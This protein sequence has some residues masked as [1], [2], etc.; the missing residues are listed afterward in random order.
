MLLEICADPAAERDLQNDHAHADHVAGGHLVHGRSGGATAGGGLGPSLVR[1][2]RHGQR[3]HRD[4]PPLRRGHLPAQNRQRET[5]G[6]ED[7][8]LR[9]HGENR[10]VDHLDGLERQQIHDQVG[11]GGH[12]HGQ[13]RPQLRPHDAQLLPDLLQAQLVHG[14]GQAKLRQVSA[15]LPRYLFDQDGGDR[16][17][18]HLGGQEDGRGGDGLLQNSARVSAQK[19]VQTVLGA[20]QNQHER[21]HAGFD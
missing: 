13:A 12:E 8:Q 14:R 17:L 4:G 11:E 19:R 9:D 10:G 5:G 2:D 6:R 18:E 1:D 3:Q 20:E 15:A 16:E 7:L 21:F